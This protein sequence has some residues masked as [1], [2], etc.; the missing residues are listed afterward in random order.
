LNPPWARR[1]EVWHSVSS[2]GV[3][4][5]AA[6][7]AIDCRP[8]GLQLRGSGITGGIS[9]RDAA[10]VFDYAYGM[11]DKSGWLTSRNLPPRRGVGREQLGA[12]QTSAARPG[13]V[14]AAGDGLCLLSCRDFS[15]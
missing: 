3:Q 7:L 12:A 1:P 8:S 4:T 11:R 13:A 10:P 2:Y 14:E 15:T 9:F 6:C 5:L